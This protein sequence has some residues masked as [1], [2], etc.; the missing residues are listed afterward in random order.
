MVEV[1]KDHTGC[2][3]VLGTNGEL[4][5]YGATWS[6]SYNLFQLG[7]EAHKRRMGSSLLLNNIADTPPASLFDLIEKH[8]PYGMCHLL[9]ESNIRRS[10]SRSCHL[11]LLRSLLAIS[12]FTSE[13]TSFFKSFLLIFIRMILSR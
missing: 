2:D 1:R 4:L 6:Y 3:S 11:R 8:I 5:R 10:F 9:L 13:R 7:Q 12:R